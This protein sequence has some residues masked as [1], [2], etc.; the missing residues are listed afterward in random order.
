MVSLISSII[1]LSKRIPAGKGY[2][3][4][5]CLDA[6]QKKCRGGKRHGSEVS[7]AQDTSKFVKIKAEP[8][9]PL[10][11]R[12]VGGAW[13]LQG[14]KPAGGK[15]QN[16][17][18]SENLKCNEDTDIAPPSPWLFLTPPRDEEGSG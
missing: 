13:Q 12:K 14:F 4:K 1:R 3:S 11:L 6:H 8:I 2:V 5:D 10:V 16:F 7:S 17:L 9:N 18:N 15:V